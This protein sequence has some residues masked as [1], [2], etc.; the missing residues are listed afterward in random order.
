MKNNRYFAILLF[1]G[2]VSTAAASDPLP[3]WNVGD[4]KQSIM[5]FV[6]KV[7]KADSADFVPEPERIAVFDNAAIYH[8]ILDFSV[9]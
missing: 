3:S 2:A 5:N 8:D 6:G 4:A 9:R 1:A 7:T